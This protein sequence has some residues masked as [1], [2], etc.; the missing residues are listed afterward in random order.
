MRCGNAVC[1]RCGRCRHCGRPPASGPFRR[2][3]AHRRQRREVCGS[4]YRTCAVS[5]RIAGEVGVWRGRYSAE[6]FLWAS[7]TSS[8]NSLGCICPMGCCAGRSPDVYQAFAGRPAL[9]GR[10][11]ALWLLAPGDASPSC[12][13]FR[14]CRRWRQVRRRFRGSTRSARFRTR[15]FCPGRTQRTS[16]PAAF[17]PA[18][19]LRRRR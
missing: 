7:G 6:R 2:G 8:L 15:S 5:F 13:R 12:P 4:G 3:C 10:L 11:G 17:R 9:L 14:C 16:C 1:I 19:W 18:A